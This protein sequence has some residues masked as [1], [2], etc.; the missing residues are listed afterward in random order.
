MEILLF[1]LNLEEEERD[2]RGRFFG[3][4]EAAADDGFLT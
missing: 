3:A 4:V 2:I 1:T